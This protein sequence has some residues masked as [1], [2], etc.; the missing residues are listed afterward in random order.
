M[1][2]IVIHTYM[3]FTVSFSS[4]IHLTYL[5]RVAVMSQIICGVADVR[6]LQWLQNISQLELLVLELSIS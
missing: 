6:A 3:A 4:S 2:Q 1:V 5:R